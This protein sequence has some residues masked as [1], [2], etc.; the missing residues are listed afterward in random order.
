MSLGDFIQFSTNENPFKEYW[1]IDL[2]TLTM[3]FILKIATFDFFCQGASV[4]L[5]NI[6][7]VQVSYLL[8]NHN[9]PGLSYTML[10]HDS[11]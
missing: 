4:S 7:F 10:F 9:I 11:F 8:V 3:T 6:L 1:F 5:N 2:V